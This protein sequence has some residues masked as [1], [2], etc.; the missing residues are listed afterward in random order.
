[1]PNMSLPFTKG[2]VSKSALLLTFTD[3]ICFEVL[4]VRNSPP[5]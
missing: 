4:L 1:L 5:N 3:L 2:L